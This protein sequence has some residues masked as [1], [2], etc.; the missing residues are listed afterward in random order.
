MPRRLSNRVQMSAREVILVKTVFGSKRVPRQVHRS[1]IPM[2][3]SKNMDFTDLASRFRRLSTDNQNEQ[4]VEAIPHMTYAQL[5]DYKMDFGTA[6]RGQPFA[7]VVQDGRYVQWFTENYKDSRRPTHLRLLRFIQLHVEQME[8]QKPKAKPILNAQSK[9]R[10]KPT[11]GPTSSGNVPIN[12]VQLEEPEIPSETDFEE[13]EI[14]TWEQVHTLERELQHAEEM[15]QVRDR[16]QQMEHV[17]QQVLDHLS[18]GAAPN[19]Q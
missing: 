3:Q 8:E 14:E 10:A 12:E 4:E 13:E 6:K 16:L 1:L 2:S 9:A 19:T 17:M 15:N 18:K 7:K 11:T 5:K